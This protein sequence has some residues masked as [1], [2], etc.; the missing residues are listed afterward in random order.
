MGLNLR[1]HFEDKIDV[2]PPETAGDVDKIG[3]F[4]EESP[5]EDLFEDRLSQ[6]KDEYLE[7]PN[8]EMDGIKEKD[9]IFSSI[10]NANFDYGKGGGNQYFIQNAATMKEDGRLIEISREELDFNPDTDIFKADIRRFQDAYDSYK[11]RKMDNGEPVTGDYLIHFDSR[12]LSEK[13]MKEMEES[14]VS[15]CQLENVGF[16]DL[17]K[18]Q[19]SIAELIMDEINYLDENTPSTE[20]LTKVEADQK[21]EDYLHPLGNQ[22]DSG[23]FN[24]PDNWSN[25][26]ELEEGVIYYQLSP[27]F[28][29]GST[30]TK[31]SYFTD[32]ET[33]E[34]C[35][36]EKGNVSVSDLIQKLQVAPK[37]EM[38][39]DEDGHINEEYITKYALTAFEYF[40]KGK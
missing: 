6:I 27:I 17:N 14:I 9:I 4:S 36:N 40:P 37:A 15:S 32:K 31:S 38:I 28:E 29:D 3:K 7:D 30:D 11:K 22:E 25:P 26:K 5:Y 20:A 39:K 19:S 34:S 1:E 24:H 23:G 21:H 33:V 2:V 16:S 8:K 13:E 12:G 18:D 10:A 35:R